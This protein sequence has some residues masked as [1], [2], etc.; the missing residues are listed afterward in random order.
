MPDFAKLQSLFE[1]ACELPAKKQAAFV[2]E[3]CGDDA[4][5]KPGSQ[6]GSGLAS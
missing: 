4:E 5:L 6:I 2:D 1:Q 3:A